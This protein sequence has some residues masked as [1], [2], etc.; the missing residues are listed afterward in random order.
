MPKN[1]H[2][3]SFYQAFSGGDGGGDESVHSGVET[4]IQELGFCY[5]YLKYTSCV[6][7]LSPVRLFETLWTVAHQAPLSTGFSTQEYWSGLPFP[8][9]NNLP[10]PGI[11]PVSLV[12]PAPQADSLPLRHWLPLSALPAPNSSAVTFCLGWGLVCQRVFLNVLAPPSALG[13]L[14]IPDPVSL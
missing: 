4:P 12:A 10:D 2:T 1:R 11:K 8:S 7:S 3:T 6:Q 14:C 5:D 13:F 9:P